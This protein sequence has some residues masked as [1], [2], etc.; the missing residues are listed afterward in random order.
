GHLA[1]PLAVGVRDEQ[2][3]H[4]VEA[5]QRR[6]VQAPDPPCA[7]QSDPHARPPALVRSGVVA[8]RAAGVK[9]LSVQTYVRSFATLAWLME[10]TPAT[11]ALDRGSPVPL[12]Y[13]LARVLEQAI[14]AGTLPVGERLDNEIALAERL[15]LSRATVRSAI[16]YLVERGLVV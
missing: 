11:I 1:C 2:L 8:G 9:R 15:A 6:R 10:L 3:R 12:Y 13:Q 7:Y 16:G 4:A 5:R 14:E